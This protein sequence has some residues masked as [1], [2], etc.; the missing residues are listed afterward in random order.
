MGGGVNV[1]LSQHGGLG[2]FSVAFRGK[3]GGEREGSDG[4]IWK[5]KRKGTDQGRGRLW[6][7]MWEAVQGS[8]GP[9]GREPLLVLWASVFLPVLAASRRDLGD[10]LW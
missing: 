2:L 8:S 4:L 10:L 7:P 3:A 1:P 5:P 9:V 6:G